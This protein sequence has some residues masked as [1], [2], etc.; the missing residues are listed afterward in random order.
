MPRPL[1]LVAMAPSCR[2]DGRI[3]KLEAL[4]RAGAQAGCVIA[5]EHIPATPLIALARSK[6]QGIQRYWLAR[7]LRAGMDR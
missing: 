5:A 6:C 2:D 7:S 4:L 3:E 1:T